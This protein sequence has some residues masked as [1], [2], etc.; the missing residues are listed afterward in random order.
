MRKTWKRVVAVLCAAV[1]IA[2]TPLTGRSWT[3]KADTGTE[4]V[5]KEWSIIDAETKVPNGIYQR[6]NLSLNLNKTDAD[7]A[8]L[9]VYIRA[10]LASE[11]AVTTMKGSF[12]E[13]S[14][15]KND[16]AEIQWTLENLSVG[17][18]LRVGENVICLKFSE[19][20]DQVTSTEEGGS[21]LQIDLSQEIKH[22]RIFNVSDT[23]GWADI[24]LKE[25][26]VA[27]LAPIVRAYTDGATAGTAPAD[28]PDGYAFAGWY[29]D[30]ACTTVLSGT[31]T[32]TAYAKFVNEDV[33]SVKA[34]Y[35]LQYEEEDLSGQMVANC[36]SVEDFSEVVG[37][38]TTEE[39]EV[40]E[41]TGAVKLVGKDQFRY[42]MVFPAGKEV[43][44]A[45]YKFLHLWF[46]VDNVDSLNGN[47]R[48]GIGSGGTNDNAEI[49]WSVS[50]EQLTNGWNELKL[51][52]A[53]AST[54]DSFQY[55]KINYMRIYQNSGV[56]SSS[57]VTIVDDV[58]AVN[59]VEGKFILDCDTRDSRS[60]ISGANITTVEGEYKEG[61]GAAKSTSGQ[62]R[63]QSKLKEAV[64]IS[65]Y[66]DG[67]LHLWLYVGDKSTLTS[68][69]LHIEISSSGQADNNELQWNVSLSS[70]NG[71][72][73]NELNLE[74]SEGIKNG[75]I[76][77]SAVNFVRVYFDANETVDF[78]VDDIR[79]I[80][81]DPEITAADVRFVSTVDTL[82]YSK[83]GFDFEIT[84]GRERNF[85]SNT[86]YTALKGMEDD[87]TVL[88]YP[89]ITVAPQSNYFFTYALRN[90]PSSDF[91]V[92]ITATPYW[93]TRDGTKVNGISRTLTVNELLNAAASQN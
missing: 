86:V 75:T 39:E 60:G 49:K 40:K 66:A 83:I 70:L 46:Y 68:S 57:I 26:K 9:V 47:L 22:F 1:L 17:K 2:G 72:S 62:I 34:Q 18:E 92:E 48:I 61:S 35:K 13:L 64:D 33:M 89:P 37:S 24:T 69:S 20:I 90:I 87:G 79:A 51:D 43:D 55:K 28:T 85:E 58:R 52:F 29:T 31:A 50:K 93:I 25:V 59:E 53:D 77:L 27:Y 3:V 73:W 11:A 67:K 76:D 74:L 5:T 6:T 19:G 32:G 78:I 30:E 45:G 41:G 8:N 38:V 16:D 44:I 42:R 81:A 36:D 63:L 23:S 21:G 71:N 88:V 14:Q 84:S 10:T 54:N 4:T 15:V 91:D 7:R 12:V 65:E 82:D 80:S 56:A